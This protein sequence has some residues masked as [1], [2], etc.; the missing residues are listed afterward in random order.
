MSLRKS[1]TR[2]AALLA[3]NR[4]NAQKSTGPRTLQG[5]NRVALSA[6]RHGLHA[7]SFLPAFGK[8]AL[9]EFRGLYLALYAALLPDTT[10]EA[11]MDLPKRTVLQVW[12]S[13]QELMR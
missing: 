10:D 12:R 4:A 1:P 8:S 11:A 3:V 13:K 5:K 7:P 6:L 2:T 9:Q